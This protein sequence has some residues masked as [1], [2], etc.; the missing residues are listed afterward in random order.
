MN[1]G[2]GVGL[3]V[4]LVG[5]YHDARVV[6]HLERDGIRCCAPFARHVLVS[7]LAL[8]DPCAGLREVGDEVVRVRIPDDGPVP[9][10][11]AVAV[12]CPLRAEFGLEVVCAHVFDYR[13][14]FLRHPLR[15]CPELVAVVLRLEAVHLYLGD[16]RLDVVDREVEIVGVVA[17]DT[18]VGVVAVLRRCAQH[19]L[20]RERKAAGLLAQAVEQHYLARRRGDLVLVDGETLR[21]GD[22]SV[23]ADDEQRIAAEHAGL[24]VVARLEEGVYRVPGVV[25]VGKRH[26]ERGHVAL[27]VDVALVVRR[28]HCRGARFGDV[29]REGDDLGLLAAYRR[30]HVYLRL[31]VAGGGIANLE[32]AA[33]VAVDER[34]VLHDPVL[35]V[36]VL[37]GKQPALGGSA[38]LEPHLVARRRVRKVRDRV[39]DGDR[40]LV[41][42]SAHGGYLGVGA[43]RDDDRLVGADPHAGALLLRDDRRSSRVVEARRQENLVPFAERVLVGPK[44]KDEERLLARRVRRDDHGRRIRHGKRAH[45]GCRLGEPHVVPPAGR[46][47]VLETGRHGDLERM[48]VGLGQIYRDLRSRTVHVTVFANWRDDSGSVALHDERRGKR[49]A[50]LHRHGDVVNLPD[51]QLVV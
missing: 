51:V 18:L 49:F 8:E 6:Q 21:L 33:V 1:P 5:R 40:K 15:D 30:Y 35:D 48:V 9:A 44:R 50:A 4:R 12:G 14:E 29:R 25:L 10:L 11:A 38:G 34:P 19:H 47:A 27:H 42:V 2:L 28:L 23:V 46:R 7:D 43:G 13:L 20:E 32:R 3:E 37:V 16:G 39:G 31:L 45:L 36:P 26:L 24:G 41:F 22:V 17:G